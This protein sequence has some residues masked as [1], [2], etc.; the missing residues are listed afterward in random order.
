MGKETSSPFSSFIE[1]GRGF[2]VFEGRGH[3]VVYVLYGFKVGTFFI[4]D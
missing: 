4:L 2:L 1:D 3:A